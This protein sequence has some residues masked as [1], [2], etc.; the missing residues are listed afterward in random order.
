[1]FETLKDEHHRNW[2]ISSLE[3]KSNWSGP[4]AVQLKRH[5]DVALAGEEDCFW[6]EKE[7]FTLIMDE[8]AKTYE[9]TSFRGRELERG[10]S[11]E[12]GGT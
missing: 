7:R 3:N 10:A 1:M 4:S 5:N 11:L 9:W 12:Y 6:H 8:I 2:C